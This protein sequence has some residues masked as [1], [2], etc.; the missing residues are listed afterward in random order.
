M[1]IM[2]KILLW[3]VPTMVLAASSSGQ[4]LEEDLFITHLPD[5]RV[6]AHFTFTATWD[7]HPLMFAQDFKG[8]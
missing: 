2:K 5:A 8:Y 6:M 3:L 4:K 7:L 1:A